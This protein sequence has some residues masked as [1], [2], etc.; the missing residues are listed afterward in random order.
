MKK[1]KSLLIKIISFY[2]CITIC[3][4]CLYTPLL[5][6]AS[7]PIYPTL[8]VSDVQF[9]VLETLGYLICGSTGIGTNDDN[10][11]TEH[12][13]AVLA[14]DYLTNS[15]FND[16]VLDSFFTVMYMDSSWDKPKSYDELNWGT[17]CDINRDIL[18]SYEKPSTLPNL[19]IKMKDGCKDIFNKLG[20][21]VTSIKNGTNTIQLGGKPITL[22]DIEVGAFTGFDGKLQ[23][24]EKGIFHHSLSGVSHRTNDEFYILSSSSGA[25]ST[26]NK[27]A[28][29]VSDSKDGMLYIC[30]LWKS[31]S[32]SSVHSM[33]RISY[34][35]YVTG[36]DR[37]FRIETGESA[38]SFDGTYSIGYL[39]LNKWFVSLSSD[40]PIFSSYD[41]AVDYLRNDT[42]TDVLNGKKDA[43]DHSSIVQDVVS[44]ALFPL[45]G[46]AVSLKGL[47][48][49]YIDTQE[50]FKTGNIPDTATYINLVVNTIQG[51]ETL[52]KVISGDIDIPDVLPDDNADVLEW[53]KTIASSVIVIPSELRKISLSALEMSVGNIADSFPAIRR[54]LESITDIFPAIRE[55]VKSIG[56]GFPTL[57]E[58]VQ[59]IADDFPALKQTLDAIGDT[60]PAVRDSLDSIVDV[61]PGIVDFQ[62]AVL[63]RIKDIAD[64]ALKTG[65]LADSLPDVL[66]GL[67]SKVD[68]L[69]DSFAASIDAALDIPLTDIASKADSVAGTVADI[70]EWLLSL[71]DYS[72][73]LR[74]II[75]LLEKILAKI[76]FLADFF[77]LDT[78]VLYD[79]LTQALTDIQYNTGL[80]PLLDF[81]KKIKFSD[82]YEYPKL[83]MGMPAYTRDYFD[84]SEIVL[85]DTADYAKQFLYVRT[86]IKFILWF[87]YGLV[88]FKQIK[89]MLHI[90]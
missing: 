37:W 2:L 42:L 67:S 85:I 88:Q 31:P 83:K 17:I 8:N 59:S 21:F 48:D 58:G 64:N 61:F 6:K 11:Y 43:F 47:R 60:F 22:D 26:P 90:A 13:I 36:S 57:R 12:D 34:D 25:A 1:Y 39:A 50:K 76:M 27:N 62:S 32:S 53:L 65:S 23:A 89:V 15:G 41:S 72:D 52:D 51:V 80:E 24:D 19:Y 69:A 54:E 3:F 84:Q 44:R 45:V 79:A 9:G 20:D 74:K 40:I 30:G 73:F 46:T 35:N 82:S 10:P 86:L 14:Y 18:T 7:A 70:K 29:Y 68:S 4:S 81:Y 28:L 55:D 49:A 33:D 78:T 63:P 5:V 87:T 38:S 16:K 75:E 77:Q 71:P 56:D 66:T